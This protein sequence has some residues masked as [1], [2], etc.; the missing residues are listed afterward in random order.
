MRSFKNIGRIKP[1][2]KDPNKKP[3]LQIIKEI[4]ILTITKKEIPFYYFKY[5]YRKKVKNYQDYL[6]TKE[7]VA[8]G[9]KKELHKPEYNTIIEDK[10]YFC[11]LLKQTK[12][13]TPK[14]VCYNFKSSFFYN[15]EVKQIASPLELIRFFENVFIESNIENLF[16]RPLSE[17]GGKGCFKL[18][19]QNF[20]NQIS[21]KYETI[22]NGHFVHTE[23]I[24]QHESI[25]KIHRNSVCTLRLISFVTPSKT[26]ELIGAFIRF[27]VGH[28]V[29][30]NASSG[31]FIVGINMDNGTLKN[32]GHYLPE[33]GA[34]E[35]EKH[36]DSGFVFD[37]FKI[38]F[39]KEA[40]NEVV[41]AVK[42]IPDRFIGWDIAIS[43]DG[44]TIIEANSGPHLPLSDIASGGILK[45]PHIKG[46]VEAL[47][48]MK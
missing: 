43:E 30:D 1:F 15:N 5:I 29:V 48:S 21:E 38:P 44:P 45:N 14:L 39:F 28:S 35:I 7:L 19:K 16:F 6:S 3:F 34:A 23:V 9:S 12:I 25:N 13:N 27:G 18:T 37:G 20:K 42:I 46:L 2:I 17:Y 22:I 31:G 33:F 10:L 24:K 36:P 8:I 41:K 47:K 4:L 26:V 40:C 11:L 32:T